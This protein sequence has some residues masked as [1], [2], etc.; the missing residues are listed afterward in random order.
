MVSTN[1]MSLRKVK[2]KNK[3]GVILLICTLRDT[4]SR[5]LDDDVRFDENSDLEVIY[6]PSSYSEP[7]VDN[8][9][10]YNFTAFGR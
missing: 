9:I 3:L 8:V 5:T 6:L 1:F 2:M 4:L 7:L 10:P